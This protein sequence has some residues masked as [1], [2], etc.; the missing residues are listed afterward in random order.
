MLIVASGSVGQTGHAGHNPAD[1]S[2]SEPSVARS[3]A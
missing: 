1:G 2:G 3:L